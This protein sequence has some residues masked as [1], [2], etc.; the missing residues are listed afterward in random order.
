MTL[1]YIYGKS[2]T[3]LEKGEFEGLT[4]RLGPGQSA[5]MVVYATLDVSKDN[6]PHGPEILLPGKYFVEIGLC[7]W[8]FGEQDTQKAKAWVGGKAGL[9]IP[10]LDIG[11]MEFSIPAE[12]RVDAC[13]NQEFQDSEMSIVRPA[14]KE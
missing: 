1:D 10:C 9:A 7:P 4:L 14:G 2:D 5:T 13:D 11:P 12:R 3:P 6:Q 8:G